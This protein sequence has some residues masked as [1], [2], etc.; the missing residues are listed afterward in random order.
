MHIKGAIKNIN[1]KETPVVVIEN[2]QS[3][4]DTFHQLTSL[5]GY[6]PNATDTEYTTNNPTQVFLLRYLLAST[7]RDM[8][9]LDNSTKHILTSLADLVTHPYAEYA[10]DNLTKISVHTPYHEVYDRALKKI[11]AYRV[12]HPKNA[13]EKTVT[14]NML[15]SQKMKLDMINNDLVVQ[16]LPPIYI[17]EEIRKN[18]EEPFELYTGKFD[19]LK[20]IPI[21]ELSVVKNDVQTAKAKTASSKTLAQK[22]EALGLETL[23]DLIMFRPR[24]YIDKSKPQS[25]HELVEK[26]TA[27]II[28]VIKSKRLMANNTGVAF[29][30]EVK[31]RTIETM[32]FRQNWLQA[33]FQEGEEVVVTGKVSFFRGKKNING[34]SIEP[35]SEASQLPIVPVYKQAPSQHVTTSTILAMVYEMLQRLGDIQPPRFFP[36][37]KHGTFADAV[38]HIHFP[39]TIEQ[40]YHARDYLAY[41]ELLLMQILVQKSKMESTGAHGLVLKNKTLLDE[42]FNS[43]PFELTNAQKKAISTI[44][45]KMESHVPE[46]ILLNGD[47]GMGKTIVGVLASLQAVGSGYQVAVG[48]PMDTLAEQLYASFKRTADALNSDV[49]VVYYSPQ[50]KAKAKRDTLA[51]IKSGEANIIVA[52]KSALISEALEYNNLGFVIVDEQHK[53]GVND[54]SAILSSRADGLVPH[55]LMQTA[56]P[57]PRSLAQSMFGDI[58]TVVLDEK[59]PGQIEIQTTW[60]RESPDSVLN[61]VNHPIWEDVTQEANLGHQTFIFA[62][63]V[64]DNANMDV[65]SVKGIAESVQR[66]A[67]QHLNVGIIH[68]KMKPKDQQEAMEKFRT[69]EYDVLVA[70]TIVEVGIDIPDATRVIVFSAERLG[71]S[72]LHQIRGRVGRSSLPSKC[73]LVSSTDSESSV[74]RLSAIEKYSDGFTLAE[75]DLQSRGEGNVFSVQQRGES[76]M[77]F[78][79]LT[80]HFMYIP[81]AQEEAQ[82]ILSSIYAVTAID[83]AQKRFGATGKRL[84]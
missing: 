65:S 58:T 6:T 66:D 39:E 8:F 50:L 29:T 9:T 12:R 7:Y 36:P 53:F 57:V 19:E 78:A 38:Q 14:Y 2:M 59:P 18:T 76:D 11:N 4:N 68:G 16:G 45:N 47:V 73:Y 23:Y 82:R 52:S 81:K 60:V 27:T 33:K 21:S 69:K 75:V 37:Y 79:T 35:A 34:T 55:M 63:F 43:L 51:S 84:V 44:T 80:K 70:S 20:N 30:I 5:L 1:N 71:I 49:N 26:E 42:A 28:G 83:Y 77:I 17:T 13:T 54:R 32:F 3:D 24:R 31:G 48:S 46:T 22:L 61:D 10:T 56:T 40:F 25:L 62:P 15:A 41:T 72:S 67:L 74:T 64:D